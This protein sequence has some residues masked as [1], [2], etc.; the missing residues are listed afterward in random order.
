MEYSFDAV[1]FDLDGVVTKT[2]QVH[3]AAWKVM[4]DEYLQQRAERDSK[5]FKEFTLGEDYLTY[6]D[7][8][9]REKGIQSFLESRQ[10][11]IPLG[12][13]SDKIDQETVCGLGNRKNLKFCKALERDG[14][15]VYESTVKLMHDLKAKSIHIGVASSSKNCQ[16]ILQSTEL[17]DLFETRVDGVVSAE[18]GLKGKPEADIFIKATENMGCTPKRTVIVEDAVSGVQAG[19]NGN[20][21]L[22][23]GLARENNEKELKANGG[24]FVV[25]DFEG[26]LTDKLEEWFKTKNT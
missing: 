2:S 4:F 22:V 19:R 6:V 1:V 11:Q 23:V 21:G 3:A 16:F 9:P 20:F 18:L 10:I 24:D 26:I 13:P 8:K 12:D 25:D 7:G 15:E 14:V 17:E 5:T